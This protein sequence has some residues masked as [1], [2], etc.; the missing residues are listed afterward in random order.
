MQMTISPPLLDAPPASHELTD[1]DCA[2]FATYLPLAAGIDRVIPSAPE[3]HAAIGQI[4]GSRTAAGRI[5]LD[6]EF[7]VS[8]REGMIHASAAQ[9]YWFSFPIISAD[10]GTRVV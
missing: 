5:R 1:C 6:S 9:Y 4:N 8:D 3:I 2:Q 10:G 7:L